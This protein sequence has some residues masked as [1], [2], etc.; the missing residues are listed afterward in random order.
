MTQAEPRPPSWSSRPYTEED[1]D[2]VLAL[3]TEPDFHYRTDQPDTRPAWEIRRLIGDDTRVLLADGRV[4]GLYALSAEGADHGCHYL[5][6]LRLK[7]SAPD[8]W[9]LDA[10]RE[11]L[12][13]ARWRHEIV[14]LSTRFGEYDARGLEIAARLGLVR[15]G[16]L[17]GVTARDGQR[18][19]LVFFSQI[20]TPAS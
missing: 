6:A 17:T 1:D 19:G 12:R 7:G 3:F 14:R 8:A 11:I 18:H 16:T 15:E 13:A 9:W 10:Y 2:E 4:T 5:L 20:W